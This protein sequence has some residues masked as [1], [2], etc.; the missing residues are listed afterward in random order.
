MDIFCGEKDG[1]FFTVP[2]KKYQ[3]DVTSWL[4]IQKWPLIEALSN[5]WTQLLC[6]LYLIAEIGVY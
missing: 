3:G 2:P 1:L 6:C 5:H 4:I